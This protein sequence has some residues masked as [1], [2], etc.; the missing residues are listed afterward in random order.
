MNLT[1][2]KNLLLV[3]LSLIIIQLS[4]QNYCIPH[5]FVDNNY[6][7]SRDIKVEKDIVYGQ[8][9][10]YKGKTEILDLD[11]LY[12]SATVDTMKKR[13]LIMMIHGGR[14]GSD[15]SKTEKY[16]PLFAQRGY[17]VANINRRK[18]SRNNSE[19]ESLKE[20]YRVVQD[21]HA[22]MRYLIKNAGQYGIDKHVFLLIFVH[23]MIIKLT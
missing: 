12:P 10:N 4:A 14:A 9:E 22:A 2:K 15:N 13:P 23:R 17:V 21:A 1:F 18:G 5:R 3:F 8:A 19:I 16:C 7:R 6:F 20:P 11:V